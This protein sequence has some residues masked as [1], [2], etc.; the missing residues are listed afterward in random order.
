MVLHMVAAKKVEQ[1]E[2]PITYSEVNKN[3]NIGVPEWERTVWEPAEQPM[4][5]RCGSKTIKKGAQVYSNAPHRRQKYQC[6]V[7]GKTVCPHPPAAAEV[8]K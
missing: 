3:V 2:I 8:K 7:C 4:C 6:V 1:K 5:P